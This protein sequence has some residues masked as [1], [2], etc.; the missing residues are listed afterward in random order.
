MKIEVICKQCGKHEFVYP[1]RA[2][3]YLTC[4][5]EC[6]GKYNSKRYNRKIKLICPMCGEEY[7]CIESG[8][9]H[10]KTCGKKECRSAWLSKIRTGSGNSNYK[11]NEDVLREQSI[12]GDKHDK[13]KTIYRHIVKIVFNLPSQKDIPTGY[14]VHHKDANHSNNNPENLVLLP[15]SAHVLIH[16]LFGNIVIS[17]LYN[18]LITK[19]VFYSMCNEAEKDFYQKIDCLDITKQE[20]INESDLNEKM[21]NDNNIYKYIVRHES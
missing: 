16:R 17:A 9:S 7:E 21:K 6:L 14:V 4:S 13:S 19:E 18:G 15:K 20:I 10:H 8:I 11:T 3:N 2:K 1:C 5:K 12:R